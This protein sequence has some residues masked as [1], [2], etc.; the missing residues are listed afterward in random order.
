MFCQHMLA[1][2]TLRLGSYF[3][4]YFSENHEVVS[5]T[6]LLARGGKV[7][8]VQ[9]VYI[10]KASQ[11]LRSRDYVKESVYACCNHTK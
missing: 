9:S 7:S 8:P 4:S 5:P 11:C 10:Y 3:A 1:F 2:P 6:V